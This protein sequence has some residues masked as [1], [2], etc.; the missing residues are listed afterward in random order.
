MR[1]FEI[2]GPHLYLHTSN[3]YEPGSRIISPRSGCGPLGADLEGLLEHGRPSGKLPRSESIHLQSRPT[4]PLG[5]CYRVTPEARLERSHNGWLT[6]LRRQASTA[7]R[8]L[9]DSWVEGYWSGSECAALSGQWEYR[10]TE[11]MVMEEIAF[12]R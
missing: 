2:E 10:T 7:D 5:T 9:I 12:H 1:L 8:P 6:L 4:E 11:V 3:H